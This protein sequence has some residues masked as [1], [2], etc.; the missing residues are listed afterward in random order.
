[1]RVQ[2]ANLYF[3]ARRYA[4][5]I[6]PAGRYDAVRIEIGSGSGR[7]WWCVV[8]PPLC[9][10]AASDWE[11][12]AIACGM[13]GEDVSLMAGEAGYVLKFRSLE[14]WESLRQRLGL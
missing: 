2:L 3:D 1:M 8:F 4:N 11:E 6:L 12:T 7:N 5:G 10:A 9:T 14:L 13:E